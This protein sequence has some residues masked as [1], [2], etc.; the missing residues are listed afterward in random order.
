MKYACFLFILF[1]LATSCQTK[2]PKENTQPVLT[3]KWTTDTVMTTCESV[4]YDKDHDVLYVANMNGGADVKD[5]NGFISKVALDGSVSSLNWIGGMDAP[6]GMGLFNGKLFVADIDRIHEVDINAGK[7]TQTY[8][9]P[10]AKF[11]NDVTVDANGRVFSSD[12]RS[13][14]IFMIQNGKV[15]KWFSGIAGPNGLLSEGDKMLS[16]AWDTQ[17][18]NSIDTATKQVVMKADSIENPDGVEAVGDGGYLVSSWNGMIHYVGADG[19]SLVLL[20]TRAD[21][22]SAADIEYIPEKKLLLVP[23][24]YKNKVMA[25]ELKN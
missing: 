23:T 9:L 25:Y 7:I 18:M 16:L 21:S 24:F 6:K 12:S 8:S 4:I 15:S 2:S 3:L 22:L 1:V 14:D 5:G 19:K 13:G 10:E 11:L 17:T 20:D